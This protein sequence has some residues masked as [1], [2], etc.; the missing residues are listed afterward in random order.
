VA[1][2]EEEEA[3]TGREEGSRGGEKRP[4]D[5]VMAEIGGRVGRLSE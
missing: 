3:V 2:A 1:E 5:A 4:M